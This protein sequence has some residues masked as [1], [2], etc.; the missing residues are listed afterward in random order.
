M[1]KNELLFF[2]LSFH[3]SGGAW[4]WRRK[5]VVEME[6]KFLKYVTGKKK[7]LEMIEEKVYIAKSF[8]VSL[9]KVKGLKL[10]SFF[11][12]YKKKYGYLISR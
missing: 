4:K 6:I 1:R 11:L 7:L 2:L 10:K 8:W 5:K 3:I 9:K 12:G